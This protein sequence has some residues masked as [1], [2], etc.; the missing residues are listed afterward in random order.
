MVVLYVGGC[1][2]AVIRLVFGSAYVTVYPPW[3]LGTLVLVFKLVFRFVL[4]F[5]I[6]WSPFEYVTVY[7][8]DGLKGWFEYVT[9]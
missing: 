1:V 9:V 8:R 7:P 3:K 2:F 5:L 4:L 6:D